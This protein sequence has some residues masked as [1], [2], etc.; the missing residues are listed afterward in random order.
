[1]PPDKSVIL[2][3]IR[4]VVSTSPMNCSPNWPQDEHI[5]A[6]VKAVIPT[7]TTWRWSTA[8]GCTPNDE[9]FA[10][11]WTWAGS[12]GGLGG[13]HV[14]APDAP[15]GRRAGAPRGDRTLAAGDY[16]CCSWQQ[17][18]HG[19]GRAQPARAPGRRPTACRWFRPKRRTWP[20]CASR[21]KPRLLDNV[22][23]KSGAGAAPFVG[24]R[25]SAL[26]GATSTGPCSAGWCD[27]CGPTRQ[28]LPTWPAGMDSAGR[29][30]TLHGTVSPEQRSRTCSRLSPNKSQPGTHRW[31]RTT[32][33][34]GNAS[35][36]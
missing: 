4:P 25:R 30:V 7:T 1:V 19:Q 5:R 22:P 31:L 8:W 3:N 13:H 12:V 6:T 32:P 11:P 28:A 16:A 29:P 23:P 34:G 18:D 2:Y 24:W 15:D 21:W 9:T 35:R 10:A 36:S 17:P 27:H 14:W 20:C 33:D 26:L